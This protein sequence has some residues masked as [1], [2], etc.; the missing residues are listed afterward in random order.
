[1][2]ASRVVGA[3]A[4]KRRGLRWAAALVTTV[5]A[6]TVLWVAAPNNDWYLPG[7][8]AKLR[9]AVDY[10]VNGSP[11]WVGVGDATHASIDGP[12]SDATGAVSVGDTVHLRWPVTVTVISIDA[13]P[14]GNNEVGG[15]G[16][17]TVRIGLG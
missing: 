7:Q 2:S 10:R 11:L 9:T 13:P 15:T 8:T 4:P 3:G 5:L 12:A 14:P 1:M 17:V 16:A 6:F